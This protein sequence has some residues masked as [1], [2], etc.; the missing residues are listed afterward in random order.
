MRTFSEFRSAI[1]PIG[2][3][4]TVG[5]AVYYLQTYGGEDTV[6][7]I[8]VRDLFNINSIPMS[9]SIIAAHL[10]NLEQ[11]GVVQRIK[12]DRGNGYLLTPDG[13]RR[14]ERRESGDSI[15]SPPPEE[16]N[17]SDV[18]EQYEQLYEEAQAI[19]TELSLVRSAAQRWRKM[20]WIW[21]IVTLVFGIL[22]GRYF[23]QITSILRNLL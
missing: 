2:G 15:G 11:N 5:L 14:F 3:K 10:H 13:A 18:I 6:S 8:D 9:E 23:D 21:R 1:E 22:F 19:R 16:V 12:R 20:S 7:A 17:E 4:E